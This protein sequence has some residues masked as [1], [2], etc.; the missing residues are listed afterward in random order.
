MCVVSIIIQLVTLVKH[1]V[2][3]NSAV[4]NIRLLKKV[5]LTYKFSLQQAAKQLILCGGAS[6]NAQDIN[7]GYEINGI[8]MENHIHCVE[9]VM[10]EPTERYGDGCG[11][12]ANAAPAPYTKII[13]VG[14]PRR[15]LRR[16]ALL[17]RLA[18]LVHGKLVRAVLVYGKLVR[19]V[20]VYGKLV[21]AVLVH[22]KLVRAVFVHGK[23]VRAVLVCEIYSLFAFAHVLLVFWSLA[24]WLLARER[25]P[26]LASALSLQ[27][28]ATYG[29]TAQPV[30]RLAL[31]RC[32][33][34]AAQDGTIARRA[35]AHPHTVA[36]PSA[37]DT[38]HCRCHN[39]RL[40]TYNPVPVAFPIA[41][42]T[43]IRHRRNNRLSMYN[44]LPA[45][46]PIHRVPIHYFGHNTR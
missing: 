32:S 22:G 41:R 13:W 26:T 9:S 30:D 1:E 37:R 38:I 27:R 23:F 15:H 10:S 34:N 35:T 24:F 25:L 6:Y 20:F 36:D 17:H 14:V 11:K 29:S 16:A 33:P 19:A 5:T 28:Y 44:P 7:S 40:A 18:V 8:R 42:G 21:R 2:V 46:L 43:I 3:I 12:H 4:P 39:T 45:A 31:R